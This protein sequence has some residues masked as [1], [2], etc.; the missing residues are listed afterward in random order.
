M[1][2]AKTVI[3]ALILVIVM[4]VPTVAFAQP[5]PEEVELI[6]IRAFFESEG[7]EVTWV[8]ENQ[9]I[10][11]AVEGGNIIMFPNSTT[12]VVNDVPVEI[13][14][15]VILDYDRAFMY[16][17]DLFILL[18]I[19]IA[20]MVSEIEYPA[21]I[22]DREPIT[23]TTDH[24]QMAVEFITEMNDN[25]YDRIAF[26]YRELEAA[27][28]IADQLVAMGH[29]ETAIEIQSIHLDYVEDIM[30]GFDRAW[31]IE[32]VHRIVDGEELDP[33]EF[34]Q[35]GAAAES[36][37]DT[38]VAVVAEFEQM[39]IPYEMI[40]EVLGG[41]LTEFIVGT[42][43]SVYSTYG[44]FTDMAFRLYSQNVILTIPGQSEQKIILTAHYDTIGVPGASDNASG[45][46][47][48]LESAYR[49]L[50]A[51]NYY[52]IVYA[53][54]GAEEV[55]LAGVYYYY[56]SLT[57]AQQNNIV[58][59]INADVLFEGPYF[60]VGAAQSTLGGLE[61]IT[62]A[63][64]MN[65]LGILMAGYGLSDNDT[66]LLV[67]ELAEELNAAFG[68]QLII[69]R[70]AAAMPSDQLM[71]LAAGHTVV[72]LAGVA[73]SSD[74]AYEAFG[75]SPMFEIDGISFGASVVHSPYDDV[76][77]INDNWP[78]KIRNAMW[79]FSLFL[80]TV[81]SSN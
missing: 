39:G 45:V 62:A 52:T 30:L 29:D 3:A 68:T 20:T 49:M 70:Y 11:I 9:S 66:S 27:L 13:G 58:L 1:K 56:A 48:L 2:R 46:A 6:P 79:T 23:R 75:I 15:P 67:N 28:W 64:V 25:L 63:E 43:L 36:V 38:Y 34:M 8:S 35:T 37:Q 77:F 4:A 42:L 47:L 26:T 76:H 73:R 21:W 19:F 31:F 14:S 50:G 59:N 5:A 32:A 10:H 81:L 12:A 53:F 72:S 65:A 80:D 55:G 18:E 17:E 71:F 41:D 74:T 69:W 54:V 40:A 22:L 44:I 60:L 51:D 33:I 24:G 61:T 7:A 78:E 57:E 16:V